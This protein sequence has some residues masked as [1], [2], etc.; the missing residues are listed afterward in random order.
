V[1]VAGSSA[2]STVKFVYYTSGQ[3]KFWW[4]NTSLPAGSYD[5]IVTDPAASGGL[6]ATLVGGFVVQ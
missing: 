6:S 1:T 2:T 5:V 3:V 4:G